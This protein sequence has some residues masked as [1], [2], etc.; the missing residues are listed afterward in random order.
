MPGISQKFNNGVNYVETANILI[1]DKKEKNLELLADVLEDEYTVYKETSKESALETAKKVRPDLI[2]LDRTVLKPDKM[3]DALGQETPIIVLLEADYIIGNEEE[4]LKGAVDY[5]QKPLPPVVVKSRVRNHMDLA[6]HKRMLSQLTETIERMH[7]PKLSQDRIEMEWRRAMREE[8]DLSMLLVAIDNFNDYD[9]EQGR[10]IIRHVADII[11]VS[12]KRAMDISTRWENEVFVVLLPSTPNHGAAMLSE[13]I[14]NNIEKAPITLGNSEPPVYVK[15]T[16]CYSCTRPGI[17]S[18]F[19]LF[20]YEKLESFN[21][22]RDR[23][24]DAVYSV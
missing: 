19:G 15:V 18:E 5:I 17:G 20:L 1:V 23:G 22:L 9:E 8:A 4:Y 24:T 10:T 12:T 7:G 3:F 6:A 21:K 14:R 16:V 2:I 11:K 13:I